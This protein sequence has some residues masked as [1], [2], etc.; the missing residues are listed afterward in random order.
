MSTAQATARPWRAIYDELLLSWS[1]ADLAGFAVAAHIRRADARLIVR[2]VNCHDQAREALRE[3]LAAYD[4]LARVT[5]RGG[6][7]VGDARAVLA[8]MDEE[9][10]AS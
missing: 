6:P 9:G 1:L 7:Y 8:A 5:K 10:G 4:D 3:L 2:A